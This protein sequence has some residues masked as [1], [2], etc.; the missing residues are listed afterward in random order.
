MSASLSY[1]VYKNALI[2]S[3]MLA[4]VKGQQIGTYQAETHPPLSWSTCSSGGSCTS[5]AGS[6]VLDANWRWVHALTNTTNC[7]NGNTWTS[8]CSTNANCATE[9]ALDG[10]DYSGTY[11][12]TTSGNSLQLDFVTQGSSGANVGSR[13]YLM[14]DNT[15]YEIFEL[16]NKEFTVTID[17][18]QLPC[19]LNGAL[20]FVNMPADG[21]KSEYPNAVAGAQYGVGY[22]D[23]Q[24]PSDLKFIQ[25]EGN[26]EGWKAQSN[27]KNSGNGNRGSCCPELD[28]WEGN[29]ISQALTPHPCESV[30]ATVCTGT[31]CG[32]TYSTDRYAGTCDPDGCDFNPYRVGNTE[33]YGPGKTVDSSKPVT[34]VTQFITEDGTDTGTLSEIRRYYVQNGV[35]HA[36]P[37]STVSGISGNVIDT[38]FCAAELTAFGETASFSNKGGMP[39]VS[40]ALQAGMVLV[41]S[42][43][44]DYAV[45]M[46]WLDSTYPTGSTTPGSNRGTCPTTGSDPATVEAKYPSAKVIFSD[47]RVGPINSTFTS[48]GSTGP[49]SST[50]SSA[51]STSSTAPGGTAQHWA[52]CGGI[53]YAGP[54]VCASPYTCQVS[55]PY[56]SQCL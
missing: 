23:S 13:T 44:D 11:G 18:S 50:T 28:I 8:V 38:A 10:A 30:K 52:Q 4:A 20:Y 15:H 9:C 22:C 16:L 51:P 33:F 7:Y 47:I 24:C 55:N 21:G 19:G 32:G 14:A 25:G 37:A 46:L 36:Q 42:V 5:N 39:A 48:G 41:M 40:A 34:V 29:S 17:D 45:D 26:I 12:I 3:S 56:F 1:R 27:S 31:Q 2:L 53:G 43:W 49:S 6:I 54:T 35:V